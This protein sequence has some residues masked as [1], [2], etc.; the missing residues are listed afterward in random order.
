MK[1]LLHFMEIMILMF[2]HLISLKKAH[3]TI[4]DL[5]I[6]QHTYFSSVVL[7]E[8]LNLINQNNKY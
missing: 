8:L 2:E 7:V 6:T 5:K 4:Q 1:L 3:S